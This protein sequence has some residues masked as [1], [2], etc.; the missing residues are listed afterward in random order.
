MLLV[1]MTEKKDC[2][3]QI[4]LFRDVGLSTKYMYMYI[5]VLLN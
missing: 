5:L 4:W 1:I 3:L 2:A